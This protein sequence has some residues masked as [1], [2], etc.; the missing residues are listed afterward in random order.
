MLQKIEKCEVVETWDKSCGKN[1]RR[2][3]KSKIDEMKMEFMQKNNKDSNEN[4]RRKIRI[5]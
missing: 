3:R 2:A 1:F 5:D 4:A